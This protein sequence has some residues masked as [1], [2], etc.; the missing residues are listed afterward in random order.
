MKKRFITVILLAVM[1]FSCPAAYAAGSGTITVSSAAAKPGE[2]FS[3][4]VTVNRNPGVMFL[5]LTPMYD[6][7]LL[8]L[9]SM[10]DAPSGWTVIQKANW[11][12]AAD[13]SFTGKVLTLNFKA[14][15]KA[16]GS[17]AVR[18]AV[19]A[20][21]HAEEAVS[22]SVTAGTVN[23]GSAATPTSDPSLNSNIYN[24]VRRCYSE[25]LGRTEAEIQ[26]DAEGV[27][28][29]YNN[30]K[31][32]LISADYVGYYFV[33]SPEGASKGQ[34]NNNFVTMLYRLYMNRIPDAGGLNYW[35][36]LLNNGTLTREN[37]NWWFCESDEW[38]GIKAAYSM[39]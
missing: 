21:N 22:F 38:Q 8:E 25:C 37:V 14:K 33:F 15:A 2:A 19:E 24:F 35:D 13:D 31:D 36:T 27:M 32:G 28:Y 4:S 26:A 5:S 10:T 7:D 1:F 23:L 17:T 12:G 3:L 30:I 6:A 18:L 39:K 9:V 16:S 11:D 20:Y 29:W 34:S